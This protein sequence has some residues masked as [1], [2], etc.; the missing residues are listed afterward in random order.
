MR[1]RRASAEERERLWPRLVEIYPA[2]A[3]CQAYTSR[4]IP[5]VV[6]EPA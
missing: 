6:L 3:T 2:D 4:V 5:L 1:A